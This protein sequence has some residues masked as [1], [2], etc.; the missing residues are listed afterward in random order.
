[1]EDKESR[2]ELKKMAL[3]SHDFRGMCNVIFSNAFSALILEIS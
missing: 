3:V 1:M 2:G